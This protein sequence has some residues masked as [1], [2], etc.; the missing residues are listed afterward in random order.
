MILPVWG[1]QPALVEDSQRADQSS[2]H[3][4]SNPAYQMNLTRS[5]YKAWQMYEYMQHV[6]LVMG[7]SK[8]HL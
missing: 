1:Y 4:F 2:R 5:G 3:T 8:T 6:L 7:Q